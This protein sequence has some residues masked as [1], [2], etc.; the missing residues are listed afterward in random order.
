M[1]TGIRLMVDMGSFAL[2]KSMKPIVECQRC[3]S[4]LPHSLHLYTVLALPLAL[5]AA[6][7]TCW[8]C[9]MRLVNWDGHRVPL[10]A[11]GRCIAGE[12]PVNTGSIML[13]LTLLL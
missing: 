5:L 12:F 11:S 3:H 13:L 2:L 8:S 9:S 1:T 10:S 4:P 7:R 6:Q